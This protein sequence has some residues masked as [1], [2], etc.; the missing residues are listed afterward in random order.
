VNTPVADKGF[1]RTR[2]RAVKRAENWGLPLRQDALGRQFLELGTP[3]DI[4]NTL[5]VDDILH[6][7]VEQELLPGTGVAPG[8]FWAALALGA[9][10]A[11]YNGHWTP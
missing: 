11:A 6:A 2:F 8:A 7:F 9:I 3:M 1:K 4:S 10:P 5:S